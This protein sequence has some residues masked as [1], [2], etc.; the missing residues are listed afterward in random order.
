MLADHSYFQSYH[1]LLPEWT[2]HAYVFLPQLKDKTPSIDSAPVILHA[3]DEKNLPWYY[4]NLDICNIFVLELVARHDVVFSLIEEKPA[5]SSPYYHL[6]ICQWKLTVD[7]PN[8]HTAIVTTDCNIAY[9]LR[10]DLCT[11]NQQYKRH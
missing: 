3:V 4:H 10:R 8:L 7:L 2:K 6:A 9:T 11:V 5:M 1:E